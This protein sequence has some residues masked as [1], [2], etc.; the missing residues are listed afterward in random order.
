MA[1]FIQYRENK[2]VDDAII[3][4]F[5]VL[6][7]EISYFSG[8]VVIDKHEEK[9]VIIPW[10]ESRPFTCESNGMLICHHYL[11]DSDSFTEIF[12]PFTKVLK[13]FEIRKN[14]VLIFPNF[15]GVLIR[16]TNTKKTIK[17]YNRILYNF[18]VL[19]SV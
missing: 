19:P 2:T 8:E 10:Y 11:E 6:D 5:S 3:E 17:K 18:K 13:K 15:W 12:C 16:H 7:E 9:E 4:Y 14:R 1:S